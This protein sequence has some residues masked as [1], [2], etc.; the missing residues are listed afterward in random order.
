MHVSRDTLVLFQL[1]RLATLRIVSQPLVREEELLSGGK[2]EL[3]PAINAPEDLVVVLVHLS[4]LNL[5]R[6][7]VRARAS[8]RSVYSLV[9]IGG[10]ITGDKS[11]G[12]L[13]DPTTFSLRFD[14]YGCRLIISSL[15]VQQIGPPA[16][17]ALF[18]GLSSE[19]YSLRSLLASP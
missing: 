1:T 5:T 11:V 10:E 14:H 13:K 19:L 3:F 4:L 18:D 15:R 6:L 9:T 16:I 12:H 7:R 8:Y 17:I 2:H